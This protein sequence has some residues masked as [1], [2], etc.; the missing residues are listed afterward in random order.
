[1]GVEKTWL[2]S[3]KNGYQY[4]FDDPNFKNGMS[5]MSQP[6]EFGSNST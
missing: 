3:K 1:M 6:R 4:N 2:M 5:E